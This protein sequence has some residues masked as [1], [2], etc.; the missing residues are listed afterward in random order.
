V[1]PAIYLHGQSFYL[2]DGNST[3]QNVDKRLPNYMVL[4]L[5]RQRSSARTLLITQKKKALNTYIKSKAIPVT[6]HRGHQGCETSRLPHF[7]SSSLIDHG[8]KVI[9]EN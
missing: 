7:I 5:R 8:V 9:I 1:L 3:P 2:K 4:H 6:G